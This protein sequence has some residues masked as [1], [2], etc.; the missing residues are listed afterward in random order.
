MK[1]E[2]GNKPVSAIECSEAG[3]RFERTHSDS[4]SN[5]IS[6]LPSSSIV[7]TTRSHA[8][9]VINDFG[10]PSFRKSTPQLLRRQLQ[11]KKKKKK[12]KKK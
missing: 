4:S 1:D 8:C 7:A 2:V 9:G 11:K 12:K 6:P 5:S 10:R 3:G